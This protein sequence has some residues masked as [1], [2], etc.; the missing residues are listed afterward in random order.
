VDAYANSRLTYA[1]LGSCSDVT[2]SSR[3]IPRIR[4]KRIGSVYGSGPLFLP[5]ALSEMSDSDRRRAQRVALRQVVSVVLGNG[6]YEVAAV[7]ENL[8]SD[9]VLL[10]ADQLIQVAS[11]VGL[12]LTLPP[13]EGETEGERVWCFGTVLRVEGELKEGKF[14]MAIEFHAYQL[15][16]EA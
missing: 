16:S 4:G 10:Y 6:G 13:M 3:C 8:S 12:I 1:N 11:E 9:G 5:R 15:L 2:M 7:T 14:G